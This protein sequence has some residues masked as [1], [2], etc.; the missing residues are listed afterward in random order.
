[1]RSTP[2]PLA[3]DG[4]SRQGGAAA[5]RA[6]ARAEFLM[7]REEM[8]K[9]QAEPLTHVPGTARASGACGPGRRAG[10][11]AGTVQS[12]ARCATQRPLRVWL[13]E[14]RSDRPKPSALSLPWA[15]HLPHRDLARATQAL[16]PDGLLWGP[17][18]GWPSDHCGAAGRGSHSFPAPWLPVSVPLSTPTPPSLPFPSAEG[19][20]TMALKGPR[21]GFS[22][23]LSSQQLREARTCRVRPP[24]ASAGKGW[25]LG[26]SSPCHPTCP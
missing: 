24:P 25:G 22:V 19:T 20:H 17:G 18:L 13:P 3:G 15:S 23:M 6:T 11:A 16:P 7:P 14:G 4:H 21:L 1:M 10:A 8:G 26:G 5:G 9:G 2:T 12:R